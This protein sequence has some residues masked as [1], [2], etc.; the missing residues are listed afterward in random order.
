MDVLR[1]SVAVFPAATPWVGRLDLTAERR[2]DRTVA[3]VRT[4]A[5]L[6]VQRAFYPE[7]PD[8]AHLA[9]LHTAG[10]LVGGDRLD[11]SL[12]LAADTRTL[13]TTV[14]AQKIYG[15]RGLSRRV[16]EGL[17]ATQTMRVRVGAGARGEWLPQETILFSGALF[18]QDLTVDLAAGARWCS[19]EITRLGRTA[20][21][22][23]WQ[24]GDWRSLTR[25]TRE[26]QLIW[27]DRQWLP[28]ELDLLQSV[29]GAAAQPVLGSF[30]W[31]GA[32]IAPDLLPTLREALAAHPGEW[33][34]SRLPEGLVAR[35]RGSSSEQARQGFTALL[36]LLR[37]RL[38]EQPLPVQRL[39]PT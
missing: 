34:L 23:Q 38:E 37:E 33:G 1:V 2:G 28:A 19:W 8:C 30:V 9:L 35:Y 29:N 21:G 13:L 32:A 14:A 6:K 39:W 12:D 31:L 36:A 27:Q 25:I 24:S 7:G 11:L 22:E 10:G 5:P 26:G 18:H 20:M 15:S 17:T 16:P 3:T 4:E